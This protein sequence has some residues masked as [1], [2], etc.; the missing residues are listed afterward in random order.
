[1]SKIDENKVPELAEP[2]TRDMKAFDLLAAPGGAVATRDEDMPY[3]G[4]SMMTM[5]TNVVTA[6]RVAVKRDL[7]G[8][9]SELAVLCATFG[10][11]FL[12]GWDVGKG[13]NKTRVE[14]GTIQL[15]NVLVQ[16]YGNCS[17]H[18]D[19]E[20]TDTHWRFKAFFTDYE[21]GTSVARLFQQRKK[22]SMG[23]AYEADRA[24]DMV[25]QVGQ[26]KAIRNVVLNALGT[27]RD[28]CVEE[29]RNAVVRKFNSDE[30]KAKAWAFINKVMREHGIDIKQVE[31]LRGRREKRWTVPD[32]AHT[33]TE[34]VAINDGM[35]NADEVYA[36]LEDA[37]SEVFEEDADAA[38]K[39]AARQS[40]AS[41]RGRGKKKDEGDAG[42]AGTA[43]AAAG[44]GGDVGNSKPTGE[45][46][47]R[48][49][50][51]NSR[52]SVPDTSHSASDAS[53]D[54]SVREGLDGSR[55]P[56]AGTDADADD[57]VAGG[58]DD[59]RDGGN[60]AGEDAGGED[61]DPFGG[62]GL[63]QND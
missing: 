22:S 30:S 34:M 58:S 63:F 60:D 3:G 33:Y 17:V 45:I 62:G 11:R 32:L 47:D 20:E 43:N 1:M 40:N 49:P 53:D 26:S 39:P 14:G 50:D 41:G 46:R 16:A 31:A 10:D 27:L 57:A 35:I 52:D 28:Y 4:R 24:L 61:V 9:L 21:K 23:G 8:I 44:S 59:G 51:G 6:Q 13:A 42:S 7:R 38:P 2:L 36:S 55:T 29:S 25:F 19:I 37:E 56:N 48:V 54:E 5:T 18:V 12:Y 15:A